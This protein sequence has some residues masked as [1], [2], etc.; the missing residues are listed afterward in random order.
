MKKILLLM[1][2]YLCLVLT[3]N[4]AKTVY[5]PSSWVYNSSTQEYTEG[6]NSDLQWSFSRSKQSDNCIIFWQKGFGSDPTKA[7]SLNGATMTFDPDQVL[8]VAETCFAKNINELKFVDGNTSNLSKYKLMIMMNYD[9]GWVCA[10][11]GYDFVVSALWISPQAVRPAGHS[12]AHEVGHS[13]H[14]MCF[15]EANN[16]QGSTT[17]N[18]GFHLAC[19]NGQAIWEQTAQWQANQVY[20]AEMFNESYPLFGNCPNYAFSHEWIRYQS[21]WFLYYLCQYYN[22]ITTVAQV[23]NTPMT[24][25]SEGNA[26]DFCQA[27]IKLKGL[28]AS[29]FYE[30]YFDYA[31]HCATYDFDAAASYRNNYIGNF[32]YH[33]TKLADNKYQVGYASAPQSTGFNVIELNVPAAGT[34]VT[35]NFTALEPGCQLTNA[36]PAVYNNGVANA[37]VSANKS[38]YNSM[39]NTMKSYRGFRVG[40]VFYKSD[41][42]REY[43]ND[44]IVHCT[45]TGEKTEA[46]TATVPSNTRRMF[47]VVAPALTTYVQHKWDENISNDDQWPYLFETVNTTPKIQSPYINDSGNEITGET[48]NIDRMTGLGYGASY[49]TVDFTAAKTYLGVSDITTDMLRIVN[50]D[51]TEISDYGTYDGWFNGEGVATTWG[52][53]TKICV[54]FFEAITSGDATFSVCDM[55]G[56]DVTGNTYT[57]KW[58]LKAND[59]TYTYTINVN[60]V[61]E[62]VPEYKPTIVNTIQF[63]HNCKAF[64]AYGDCVIEPYVTLTDDQVSSICSSLQINALT[65]ASTWIVNPDGNF[66]ENTTDGWRNSQGYRANWAVCENGFC[67][68][69][70][71][72]E[73]R[74]WDL[75]AHDTNFNVGDSF[76]VKWGIV[77]NDKAVVLDVTVHFISPFG[78]PETNISN[79]NIVGS[80]TITVDEYPRADYASDAITVD[81]TSAITSLGV[82]ASD[83][84]TLFATTLY[85]TKYDA[86]NGGVESNLTNEQTSNSGWWLRNIEGSNNAASAPY[87]DSDFYVESFAFDGTNMTAVVGQMPNK[88]APGTTL[89]APIYIVTG[90]K[91]YI[92]NVQ[93]NVIEPQISDFTE[94]GSKNVAVTM[95]IS[96]TGI[97]SP[98]DLSADINDIITLL[99]FTDETK[100]LMKLY[101]KNGDNFTSGSTA[102]NGGYWFNKSGNVCGWATENCAVYIEPDNAGDYSA[103]HIGQF[104]DAYTEPESP[105]WTSKLYFVNVEDGKYYTLNVTLNLSLA[106]LELWEGDEEDLLTAVNGE[107]ANVTLSR[108]FFKGWNTLVMPFDVYVDDITYKVSEVVEI[109]K[110]IGDELINNINIIRFE[111]LDAVQGLIPAN[112]PV[113]IYFNEDFDGDIELQNVKINASAPISEGT[114]FDFV[115]TYLKGDFIQEGD[116]YLGS[117]DT[118]KRSSK[119]RNTK[120]Y[121]AFMR[122]KSGGTNPASVRF[123]YDNNG[124]TTY[125]DVIN[126]ESVDNANDQWFTLSGVRISQPSNKGLYIK[127]GKKYLVK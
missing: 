38:T 126:G 121:R 54:K 82:S 94:V 127:N 100:G 9:S 37:Q 13:F 101:A 65:E 59:K 44:N 63:S 25:Q 66:V 110:F 39:S 17:I 33:A 29:Q 74:L 111:N 19:G 102:N 64:A 23:W 49:S 108:T 26:T 112:T 83:L 96:N 11:S 113:M 10:G 21:Y 1:M 117:G 35:T 3:S 52:D 61:D 27:Y 78:E 53:N 103:L 50:P 93:L 30:R 32:D 118:F 91:A 70:D 20:P 90:N 42:T 68:K 47:L 51:G 104:T 116:Y 6:N 92:V 55:N 56:A 67:T 81:L 12:L 85:T 87:E 43:Y 7:P 5:I 107:R 125:I 119:V 72:N 89:T 123:V 18:T 105:A 79:L 109:G 97:T 114:Y 31:L 120:G 71:L 16:H 28:T 4:A 14:Y 95:N 41:G 115:G 77:A 24:G 69:I 34:S 106:D 60:F 88:L 45:G 15:S 99:G 86:D 57:V 124:Q 22:D 76:N 58:A 8:A 80:Q 62:I 46:I 122:A 2:S 98:I 40:Y 75:L 73:H 48:I 84:Q 36:D